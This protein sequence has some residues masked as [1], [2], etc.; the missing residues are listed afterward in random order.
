M[1]YNLTLQC[2]CVVYVACDPR[3]GLAHTRILETRGSGCPSRKHEIGLR[4]Y[5]W[6][7]LPDPAYRT[8]PV[9]VVDAAEILTGHR[10][11]VKRPTNRCDTT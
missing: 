1:S 10:P 6:E 11:P 5:L 9:S 2:G 8:R 3:T 7:L 4:L